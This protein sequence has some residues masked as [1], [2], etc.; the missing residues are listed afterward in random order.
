[1]LP[2]ILVVTVELLIFTTRGMMVWVLGVS[3]LGYQPCSM[4]PIDAERSLPRA[5]VM[6]GRSAVA[7]QSA[8]PR[9]SIGR[10]GPPPVQCRRPRPA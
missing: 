8:H 9:C 3:A 4:V 1:M 2:M 10:S 5:V 6:L 7:G